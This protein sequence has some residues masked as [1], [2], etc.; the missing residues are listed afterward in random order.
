MLHIPGRT[1]K[2]L[3]KRRCRTSAIFNGLGG[4]P[5]IFRTPEFRPARQI[6]L[7]L[8]GYPATPGIELYL[9]DVAT[10]KRLPLK[11]TL[12]P[13]LIWR[14]RIWT[15]PPDWRGKAVYFVAEVQQASD[16]GWV[17]LRI[18]E[19]GEVAAWLPFARAANR[20]FF[21]TLEFAGFLV[22]GIAIAS[23]FAVFGPSTTGSSH[24]G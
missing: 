11:S 12:R 13:A 20:S 1:G 7:Y 2:I 10:Q 9:V 4:T 24:T 16:R 3:V 14:E 5:G 22:P 8:L 15:L 18:P 6:R 21:L 17:A 19:T 23:L